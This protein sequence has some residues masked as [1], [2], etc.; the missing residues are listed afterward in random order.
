LEPA[1]AF[2]TTSKR[3]PQAMPPPVFIMTASSVV[4]AT[5]GNR[6]REGPLSA[7]RTRRVSGPERATSKEIWPCAR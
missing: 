7:I 1:P 5:F 6:T 4:P 2:T 3:S